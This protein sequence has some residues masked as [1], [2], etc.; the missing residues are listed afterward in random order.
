MRSIVSVVAVMLFALVGVFASATPSEA[1]NIFCQEIGGE[2]CSGTLD[3]NPGTGVLEVHITADASNVGLFTAIGIETPGDQTASALLAG[4]EAGWTL[5]AGACGLGDFDVR[6]E[7][8][9][10]AGIGAGETLD[11]FF[12]L[13]GTGLGALTAESFVAESNQTGNCGGIQGTWG[14][15]H[16]QNTGPT[17]EGSLKLPLKAE[18]QAVPEPGTILLL[19]AG[20]VGLGVLSRRQRRGK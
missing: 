20:L 18:G 12:Q 6:A 5:C 16:D 13:V 9:V 19:G 14:C 4:S 2:T 15:I 17:G 3:Y 11:L 10:A 1:V 8:G 7:G